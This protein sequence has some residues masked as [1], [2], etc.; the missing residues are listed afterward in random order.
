MKYQ[1][2]APTTSARRC[3]CGAPFTV[4]SFAPPDATCG[5]CDAADLTTEDR[6][7]AKQAA[8]ERRA[9][10]ARKSRKRRDAR[11]T[12]C[13]ACNGNGTNTDGDP[14]PSCR[15]HGSLVRARGR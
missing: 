8:T 7:R 15:G 12:E 13:C 6:R 11:R 3:A 2:P 9:N 14:C 1:D 10:A 5:A 4:A